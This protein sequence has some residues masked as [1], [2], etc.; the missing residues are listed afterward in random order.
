MSAKVTSAGLGQTRGMPSDAMASVR[1]LIEEQKAAAAGQPPPTID[2]QRADLEY[3]ATLFPLPED[4]DVTDA[5]AGGVPGVW[6]RPAGVDEA[7]VVLYLHGGAYTGGSSISHRE[8]ASRI[9]RAAGARGLILDYRRAP[10]HPYPAAVDDALAAYRWLIG[11]GGVD[12]NRLAVVG[13]SAGGGLTMSTVY[14]LRA[15]AD[16]LP[17]AVVLLSPWL[18]L[19]GTGASWTDRVEVEP[20]LDVE[21]LRAAGRMYA[22]DLDPGD[23][24]VSPLH[25]DPAG[26]PPVLVQVGT[27]EVLFDDSTRFVEQAREAGVDVDLEVEDGAFHVFEAIAGVPEAVAATTRIGDFIKRH[28]RP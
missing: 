26:L 11:E 3:L 9:A 22:G 7:D 20:M 13:D 1:Q 4:V 21:R 12:P 23:P 25:E 18:D 19:L 16:P 6:L 24:R 10:E 17:A 5:D 8:L 2:Q 27:D 14:A 28:L 15:A